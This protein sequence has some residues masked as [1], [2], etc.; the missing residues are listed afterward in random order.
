[1]TAVAVHGDRAHSALGASSMS[2]WSKCPGSV[3]ALKQYGAGG[4]SIAAERGTACHELAEQV[5]TSNLELDADNNLIG[6]K[7]GYIAADFIGQTFNGIEIDDDLAQVAEDYVEVCLKE[8]QPGDKVWIERKFDLAE[9]DPPMPM[10]GTA[11]L[12]IYRPAERL[13]K[14]IDLKSGSGVIVYAENNPQLRY[15]ALGALLSLPGIPVDAVLMM[16]VQPRVSDPVKHEVIGSLELLDWTADLLDAA[17]AT[18]AIAAPLI[19]G[20]HCRWC[21]H[22]PHCRAFEN[23]AL[24]AARD[25]FDVLDG[26]IITAALPDPAEL[27]TEDLARRLELI[28]LL[29][30]WCKTMRAFAYQRIG[31]GDS[32]P[33]WKLAPKRAVRKWRNEAEAVD[34]MLGRGLTLYDAMKQK[35]ISPA[36]AEKLLK[37]RTRGLDGMD[38]LVVCE[39]SGPT[40]V[41]ESDSR[42]AIVAITASEDFDII[43]DPN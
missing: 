7:D 27:E 6:F 24:E 17:Q 26:D 35:A 18:Q 43:D 34:W 30:D 11:D 33:G 3:R 36:Q 13:L 2:R 29:E 32:I 1:M 16:I 10:F 42:P 21:G 40:L 14:V 37:S 19:A 41:P 25:E 39:S 12:V 23:R 5:L 31:R 15:Y 4:T 20:E 38:D 28:P 8:M 22:K 9:L